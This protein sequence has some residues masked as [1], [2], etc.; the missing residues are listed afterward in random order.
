MTAAADTD[1]DP[2]AVLAAGL[3]ERRGRPVRIEAVAATPL[4]TRS[5]HPIERLAVTLDTGERLPVVFKRLVWGPDNKHPWREPLVYRRLLAG[6]RFGAPELYASV[7]DEA[8]LRYWL[9]L[10]DVGD[11]SLS[12]GPPGAWRAAVRWLAEMHGTYLGREAELRALGC[13]REQDSRYFTALAAAARRTLQRADDPAVL[14]RFDRLMADYPALVAD[15]ARQPRTFVHGDIFVHN[16]MVQAPPPRVRPIDWE[17]AGVGPAAW[18]LARLLEGW[19]TDTPAFLAAYCAECARHAAGPWDERS[20]R[21]A[22]RLCDV[23]LV[24]LDIRLSGGPCLSAAAVESWLGQL[25]L[26][27]RGA[28]G[29]GGDV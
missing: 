7:Y 13:L 9:F 19:G 1:L 3:S 14:T 18:D 24:L 21:G 17:S 2:R 12:H 28:T 15:L 4:A 16:L 5:T 11:W 29:E 10:E 26:A 27:W 20:F 22:F 25:E 6:G 8:R 23:L